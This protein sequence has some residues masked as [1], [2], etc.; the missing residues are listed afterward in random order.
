MLESTQGQSHGR[1]SR[2]AVQDARE[3]ERYVPTY[4]Y[5]TYYT[6]LVAVGNERR[7]E[8]DWWG[9]AYRRPRYVRTTTLPA[10]QA[11][12]V[13]MTQQQHSESQSALAAT[14]Y[15][16]EKVHQALQL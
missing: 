15:F 14:L 6:L 2:R 9:L 4:H 8:V 5:L 7:A 3:G 16:T 11:C 13:A 1:D 10:L 12:E